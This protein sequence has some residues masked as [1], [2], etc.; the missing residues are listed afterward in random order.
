MDRTGGGIA[1][2]RG[3]E[4]NIGAAIARAQDGKGFGATPSNTESEHSCCSERLIAAWGAR[5]LE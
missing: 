2:F 5:R 3:T 4:D 1:G